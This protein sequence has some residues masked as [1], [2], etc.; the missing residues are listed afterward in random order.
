MLPLIGG[1]ALASHSNTPE[2]P[3]FAG[4]FLVKRTGGKRSVATLPSAQ[5]FDCMG[6]AFSGSIRTS[7]EFSGEI[8]TPAAFSGGI[9]TSRAFSGDNRPSHGLSGKIGTLRGSKLAKCRPTTPQVSKCRPTTTQRPRIARQHHRHRS[10]AISRGTVAQTFMPVLGTSFSRIGKHL[11][12][13]AAKPQ[14]CTRASCAYR[15]Q[16]K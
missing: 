10:R 13:N 5:Q 16:T 3:G 11:G 2:R 7:R 4:P 14:D 8:G 1:E 9:R 12:I 6:T 15:H